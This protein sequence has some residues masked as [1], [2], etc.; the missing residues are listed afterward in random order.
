[1]VF[2][3]EKMGHGRVSAWIGDAFR[4]TVDKD[5][6]SHSPN[7]ETQRLDTSKKEFVPLQ[8]GIPLGTD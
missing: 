5:V 3:F 1:M 4:P 7:A 2:L 6:A 8:R